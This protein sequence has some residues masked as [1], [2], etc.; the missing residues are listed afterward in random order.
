[1]SEAPASR[2]YILQLITQAAAKRNALWR[3]VPFFGGRFEET[4]GK[5]RF[6]KERF[7]KESRKKSRFFHAPEN[8]QQMWGC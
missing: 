6:D 3:P 7:G 8:L 4:F 5:E 2:A 1:M